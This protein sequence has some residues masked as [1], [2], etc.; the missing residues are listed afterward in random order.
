MWVEVYEK[1]QAGHTF[2]L[3][4]RN[5]PTG[6]YDDLHRIYEDFCSGKYNGSYIDSN[7]LG[8]SDERDYDTGDVILYIKTSSWR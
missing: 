1:N 7:V 8:W 4:D 2:K 6:G 3:F 5:L